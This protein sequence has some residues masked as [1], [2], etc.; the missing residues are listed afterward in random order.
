MPLPI[1]IITP[2]IFLVGY[3]IFRAKP[4]RFNPKSFAYLPWVISI[5]VISVI[6]TTILAL[7]AGLLGDMAYILFETDVE[8]LRQIVA[9]GTIVATTPVVVLTH[10]FISS[11]LIQRRI[12]PT[13]PEKLTSSWRQI[14]SNSGKLFKSK[15]L[16]FTLTTVVFIATSLLSRFILPQVFVHI[17][18]LAMDLI[19]AA[20]TLYFAY[21]FNKSEM[22]PNHTIEDKTEPEFEVDYEIVPDLKIEVDPEIELEKEEVRK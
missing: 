22:K 19:L 15:W 1:T 7:T 6:I 8:F 20:F 10:I 17:N 14:K 12:F 11:A 2:L 21:K 16:I 18:A 13:K 5:W 3:H 4:M 9:I